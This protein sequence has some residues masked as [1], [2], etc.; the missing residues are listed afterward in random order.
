MTAFPTPPYDFE[1]SQPS[2]HG[3]SAP[4]IQKPGDRTCELTREL[5][6]KRRFAS[7]ASHELRTAVAG[8]RTELEEARLH[9]DETDLG[10]LLARALGDVA[11]LDAII[12]DLRVLAGMDAGPPLKPRCVDLAEMV[13]DEV[14][15]RTD[16]F[17][18]RLRLET[19]VTVQA[20]PI[21]IGRLLTNLLDNAQR[22]ARQLVEVRVGTDG[23]HAVLTVTDDGDGVAEGE[24]ERIFQRFTRLTAARRLDH[25]GTGL[26]LAIARD[27]A[28]AH[29]G[30]L[31]AEES[32]TGGARFVLRLPL[33]GAAAPAVRRT[34]RHR[35]GATDS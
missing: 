22:H 18:V 26:G 10:D 9:P 20:V 7:D 15:R 2:P 35:R 29:I 16:R 5:E 33:S 8:L 31:H 3:R 28:H 12:T 1:A 14:A 11:R 19:G 25:T 6:N 21:R 34:D 13:R 24:R 17:D 32:E 4:V 23:D 30:S 27:I